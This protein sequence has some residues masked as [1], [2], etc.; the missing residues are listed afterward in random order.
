MAVIDVDAA[1]A[2][3]FGLADDLEP[4]QSDL[5]AHSRHQILYALGGTLHLEVE[6]GSWILPPH[7]AALLSAGTAHRVIASGQ[8]ALRTLYIAAE[9]APPIPWD[10]RVFTVSPLAKELFLYAL[11]WSHDG[12]PGEPLLRPYFQTVLGLALEWSERGLLPYRLPVPQSDALRRV[13]ER[14]QRQLGQ[15]L[16]V[17]ALARAAAM[18][19]RT[20][21]RR[22]VAELGLSPGAYLHTA[23][24]L[25]ALERLAD[26]QVPITTVALDVG[27]ATPSAFSHAFNAFSGETPREY[28]KRVTSP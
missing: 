15:P 24:M 19:E 25:A 20:L 17:P 26:P 28:R 9:L 6:G 16:S 11:R 14:I 5:H 27:F 3:A 4:F 18:S 8:V 2:P 23:R 13:T 22:F 7:R 12:D 1:R 10:C 21:Q